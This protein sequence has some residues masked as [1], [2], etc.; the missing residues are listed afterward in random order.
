MIGRMSVYNEPGNLPENDDLF[1][2]LR[3][4]RCPLIY[5]DIL[6]LFV[7]PIDHVCL[8]EEKWRKKKNFRDSKT[9]ARH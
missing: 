8:Q 2:I 6:R 1:R 4:Q 3:V 9:A 5:P 7:Y